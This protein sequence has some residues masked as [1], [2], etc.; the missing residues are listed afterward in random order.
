M[1]SVT[2][3]SSLLGALGLTALLGLAST[4]AVAQWWGPG[5]GYPGWGYGGWGPGWGYP[6]WGYPGWG[7]PGWGGWGVPSYA[8]GHPSAQPPSVGEFVQN[9]L[10]YGLTRKGP[11]GAA[12]APTAAAPAGK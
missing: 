10:G 1:K 12:P 2:R 3:P 5:W 11:R 8:V 9:P 7:Y 4:A 6:A